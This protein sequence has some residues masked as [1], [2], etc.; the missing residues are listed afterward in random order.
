[1]EITT[2]T[3][4]RTE[5]RVLCHLNLARVKTFTNTIRSN[6]TILNTVCREHDHS[7]Y[8]ALKMKS[9]KVKII[10]KAD[11]WEDFLLY[12]YHDLVNL[13]QAIN[14][15]ASHYWRIDSQKDSESLMM[16]G[17]D[18]HSR[19]LGASICNPDSTLSNF[20]LL[21]VTLPTGMPSCRVRLKSRV[22]QFA[23]V[24]QTLRD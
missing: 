8:A 22:L 9:S 3:R 19:R 6:I 16:G 15:G 18:Q 1:M 12:E 21:Q 7:H 13:S 10:I 2:I 11:E 17:I 20:A 14:L 23:E 4:P 24:D 5:D